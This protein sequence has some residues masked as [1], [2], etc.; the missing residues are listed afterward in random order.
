MAAYGRQPDS[1]HGIVPGLVAISLYEELTARV[2]GPASIGRDKALDLALAVEREVR[3]HYE[4]AR[5]IKSYEGKLADQLPLIEPALGLGGAAGNLAGRWGRVLKIAQPLTDVVKLWN[6]GDKRIN[7]DEV[8]KQA[9]V[10]TAKYLDEH[11]R[12]AERAFAGLSFLSRQNTPAGQAADAVLREYMAPVTNVRV[13][14]GFIPSLAGPGRV[15]LPQKIRDDLAKYVAEYHTAAAKKQRTDQARRD[16][17]QAGKRA[18]EQ[19]FKD[20][21]EAKARDQAAGLSPADVAR[22]QRMRERDVVAGLNLVATVVGLAD[23]DAGKAIGAVA[24]AASSIFTAKLALGTS[25]G[26]VGF[27]SVVAT[28]VIQ[29]FAT[30]LSGPDLSEVMLAELREFRAE[31]R[32]QMRQVQQKLDKLDADLAS[33]FARLETQF[34]VMEANNWKRTDLVLGAVGEA[35]LEVVG[36]AL[37]LGDLRAEVLTRL[38]KI[39]S[40]N[41]RVAEATLRSALDAGG[42]APRRIDEDLRQLWFAATELASDEL[43]GTREW[44]GPDPLLMVADTQPNFA[45]PWAESRLVNGGLTQFGR[46]AVPP[47]NLP[48]WVRFAD[49]FADAARAYPAAFGQIEK[50]YM[51]QLI[52]MGRSIAAGL[53]RPNDQNGDPVLDKLLVEYRRCLLDLREQLTKAH[54]QFQQDRCFGFDPL[55]PADQPTDRRLGVEAIAQADQAAWEAAGIPPAS[56]QPLKLTAEQAGRLE[57]AMPREVRAA[58]ALGL[59]KLRFEWYEASWGG[60]PVNDFQDWSDGG[61]VMRNEQTGLVFLQKGNPIPIPDP[62]RVR[63][64]TYL[65]RPTLKIRGQFVPNG[66]PPLS[67]L[68]RI[69]VGE[70]KPIPF[71]RRTLPLSNDV[72]NLK[73]LDL[74]HESGKTVFERVMKYN[75]ADGKFRLNSA[76]SNAPDRAD[77]A[78]QF[79][80]RT[81]SIAEQFAASP[82]KDS[83]PEGMDRSRGHLRGGFDLRQAFW[84]RREQQELAA[85]EVAIAAARRAVSADLDRLKSILARQ[86]MANLTG[87]AGPVALAAKR[88][89]GVRRLIDAHLQMTYPRSYAAS[90]GLRE[91]LADL[92]DAERVRHLADKVGPFALYRENGLLERFD[93][94]AKVIT[95]F[96]MGPRPAERHPALEAVL[97]KLVNAQV[98]LEN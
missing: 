39:G 89:T 12:L 23:R 79:T 10:V 92:P 80:Q 68:D 97:D 49:V 46:R 85:R 4:L 63:S 95:N 76:P 77:L 60:R 94:A 19:I 2:Y 51:D 78:F 24:T 47:V 40:F 14:S 84:E 36:L 7:E 5:G 35:R 13:R 25:L 29:M 43:A 27:A 71:G 30:I 21:N 75:E 93:A 56:L 91:A 52:Q 57:Q 16:V 17:V 59:G 42:A 67:L 82:F 50:Q 48:T 18:V 86:Q 87:E 61:M 34:Q 96:A 72:G 3:G 54:A 88:L 45:R 38:D 65:G 44:G 70:G 83:L 32:E 62:Y 26:P 53:A 66:Q 81:A 9:L 41:A 8:R 22:R 20:K 37:K 69:V 98:L 31:F 15:V 58:V 11:D 33:G 74:N 64:Y 6:Q 1:P 55:A 90:D 73:P 28:S